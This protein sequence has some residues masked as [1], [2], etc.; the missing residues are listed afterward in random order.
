MSLSSRT[1]ALTWHVTWAEQSAGVPCKCK[2]EICASVGGSQSHESYFLLSWSHPYRLCTSGN[3]VRVCMVERFH[4]FD[5]SSTH[6]Q[7]CR[8]RHF[9]S[10]SADSTGPIGPAGLT[11]PDWCVGTGETFPC[12]ISAVQ[13]LPA[14]GR[15]PGRIWYCADSVPSFQE[16][17]PFRVLS[18]MWPEK[19]TRN[20]FVFSSI[21]MYTYIAT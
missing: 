18:G 1:S 5:S 11:R 17:Q 4:C 10:S 16:C 20:D 12:S 19:V 2:P 15:C 21:V 3:K 6:S 9:Q 7:K 13:L 14:L 8:S